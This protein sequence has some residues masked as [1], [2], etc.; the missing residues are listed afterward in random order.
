MA[1][2]SLYC[3]S[4][5]LVS[6]ASASDAPDTFG[7]RGNWGVLLAREDVRAEIK[8][9]ERQQKQLDERLAAAQLLAAQKD[10]D[11]EETVRDAVAKLLAADQLPRLRQIS[12]QAAEGYALL[13]DV[14][15]KELKFT[16]KQREALAEARAANAAKHA[17]MKDFLARA[18]F[19]SA[20]AMQ[21][22]IEE[23]RSAAS[24][25]LLAVLTVE[26]T[27]QLKELCGKPFEFKKSA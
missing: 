19:R 15:A 7:Q 20:E 22:Y 12:W 13:D 10:Q 6:V 4:V 2:L 25:R 27:A 24:G 8:L 9:S 14:V 23:Y 1:T 3:A 18:R 21:A 26:Q 11:I 16:D 17:E 5:V